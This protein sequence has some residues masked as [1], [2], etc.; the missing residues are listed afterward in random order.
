MYWIDRIQKKIWQAN[1][2]GSQVVTVLDGII[3]KPGKN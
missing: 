1:L 3:R 2:D